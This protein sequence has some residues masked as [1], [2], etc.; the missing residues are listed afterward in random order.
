MKSGQ[1]RQVFHDYD[2][3]TQDPT[4]GY[5][6][7]PICGSGLEGTDNGGR[8]RP[9]CADCGWVH[10]VNPFPGVAVLV[11]D[12]GRI[13]I[14]RRRKGGYGQDHWCLPG[15]FIEFEE[16]FLT[17]AK[18]EVEEETGLLVA[19]ESVV[20]VTCNYLAPWLHT[21]AVVLLANVTGGEAAAGDDIVQLRWLS[22]DDA[23][24]EMAFE[25]DAYIIE[26]YRAGQLVHLPVDQ[27]F[28]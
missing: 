9:R 6:Y 27:A 5:R 16:N 24:P 2:T 21:L 14:G 20:N 23:L 10:H 13:L 11:H 12:E 22:P 4:R 19:I 28:A 7:C 17:A 3:S 1:V 18:R 15:G 26:R 8:Q 25:A